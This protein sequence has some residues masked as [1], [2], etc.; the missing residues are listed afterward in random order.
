MT[1]FIL[2]FIAAIAL[3]LAVVFGRDLVGIWMFSSGMREAEKKR[4]AAHAKHQAP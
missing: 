3:L 2:G 1:N 4:A